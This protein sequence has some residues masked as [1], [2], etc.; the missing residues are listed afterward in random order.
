MIILRRRLFGWELHE[1]SYLYSILKGFVACDN[2]KD[3]FIWK[4]FTSARYLAS[5][6]CKSVLNFESADAKLWKLV[7]IQLAPLRVKVF[8]WQLMR[9]RIATKDQIVRRRLMDMSLAMCA[10]CNTKIEK[11]DHLFFSCHFSWKIWMHCCS[12]W[13]LDWVMHNQPTMILLT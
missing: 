11:V 9:R 13:G 5:L 10:F 12:I 2:L 8:C 6:Y 4:G 3:S 1:W 7:C